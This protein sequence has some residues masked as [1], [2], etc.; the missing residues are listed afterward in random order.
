MNA[1]ILAV[2][3]ASLLANALSA[4]AQQAP[5]TAPAE[6]QQKV[7]VLS[8]SGP[9]QKGLPKQGGGFDWSNLVENDEL[10]D[11]TIIRTGL[12]SK[13]VLK[14]ADRGEIVINSVTKVGISDFRRE[15]RLMQAQ[16]GMKYGSLRAHVDSSKGP[17]DFRV[18]TPTATLSV[19]GSKPEVGFAADTGARGRSLEG[20]LRYVSK[21]TGGTQTVQPGESTEE[22]RPLPSLNLAQSFMARMW[23]PGMTPSEI[24]FLIDNRTGRGFIGGFGPRDT[25]SPLGQPD[26]N[27]GCDSQ[28]SPPVDSS[29]EPGGISESEMP[30]YPPPGYETGY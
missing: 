3:A 21:L 23:T 16:L 4:P 30:Y 8:V 18:A 17:N 22:G 19:Q 29:P 24:Q 28:F 1:R 10:D 5:A 25:G 13:V 6:P 20:R 26:T 14:M 27:S 2:I 12:G 15:G 9:A 7:T 11:L